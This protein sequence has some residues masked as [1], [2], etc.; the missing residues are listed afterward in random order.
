MRVLLG[1][2]LFIVVS[3]GSATVAMAAEDEYAFI[4]E[5]LQG[6]FGCHGKNGASQNEEYP[7]LAGQHEYYLYLQLKDFKSEAR[8]ND[9]MNRITATLNKVEMRAMA[10]YFSEQKWPSVPSKAGDEQIARGER[11]AVAGQCFQCHQ[12]NYRGA[13]GV[14]RLAGQHTEYLKKTLLFFKY[15]VRKNS[16]DKGTLLKSFSVE[17]LSAMADYLG[18]LQSSSVSN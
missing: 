12:G 9:K 6:C 13:S 15:R 18:G 5:K 17:D 1:L 3:V 10:K 2:L 11:I 14:P 7:V 4:K 16:P 8:E